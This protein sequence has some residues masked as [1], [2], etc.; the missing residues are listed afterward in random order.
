MFGSEDKVEIIWKE[1]SNLSVAK[2]KV[3]EGYSKID[4]YIINNEEVKAYIKE[5]ETK[6]Y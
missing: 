3:I 1:V 4:A 2:E 6:G 5:R